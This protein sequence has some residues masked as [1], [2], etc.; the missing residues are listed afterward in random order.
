MHFY[1]IAGSSYD[2]GSIVDKSSLLAKIIQCR[3]AN[4]P[5]IYNQKRAELMAEADGLSI[6]PG[7]VK[8]S[9][10]FK[11]YWDTNWEKI[12]PMWVFAFRKDM[13]LQVRKIISG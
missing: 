1:C 9:V 7:R 12:T 2:D 13:P 8:H 10:L 6:R 3:D 4:T 5:E 11:A